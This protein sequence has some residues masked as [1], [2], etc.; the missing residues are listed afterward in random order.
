MYASSRPGQAFNI[1]STG[2][3]DACAFS[4]VNR[5]PISR[6][7][8]VAMTTNAPDL[9]HPVTTPIDQSPYSAPP[10]SPPF[11]TNKTEIASASSTTALRVVIILCP[12]FCA[13]SGILLH[14]RDRAIGQ[15]V[16]SGSKLYYRNSICV[17]QS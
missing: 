3:A 17:S 15:A 7:P 8:W 2:G 16:V 14:T 5:T 4:D 9:I 13:Y 6:D 11:A 12:P 1:A 10:C